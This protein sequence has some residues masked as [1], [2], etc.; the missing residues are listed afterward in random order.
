MVAGTPDILRAVSDDGRFVR[1][2]SL[3]FVQLVIDAGMWRMLR[4]SPH[5]ASLLD[6]W[7]EWDRRRQLRESS[8]DISEASRGRWEH[9]SYAEIE[10]RRNEVVI[11][12]W[13]RG[14]NDLLARRRDEA[15]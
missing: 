8:W 10:R 9:L 15:A 2:P 12:G 13:A 3:E 4:T 1:V 5:V 6:E 11:P 14:G 7:S